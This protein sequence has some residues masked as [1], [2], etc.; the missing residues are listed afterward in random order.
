VATQNRQEAQIRVIAAG[1]VTLTQQMAEITVSLKHHDALFKQQRE[2]ARAILDGVADLKTTVAQHVTASQDR[3]KALDER[4]TATAT[5]VE[6]WT[7]TRHTAAGIKWLAG[8]LA[9]IAATAATAWGLFKGGTP[10]PGI[11]P[12]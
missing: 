9:V 8:L 1:H 7:A 2:D 10:P 5:A 6:S 11:G 12:Q 4:V 3:H